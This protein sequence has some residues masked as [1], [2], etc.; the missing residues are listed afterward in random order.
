MAAEAAQ[1]SSAVAHTSPEAQNSQRETLS[2]R[3]QSGLLPKR[4]KALVPAAEHPQPEPLADA[5]ARAYA[6]RVVAPCAA[7]RVALFAS[8]C[9]RWLRSPLRGA[10]GGPGPGL[11]GLRGGP[12]RAAVP[13]GRRALRCAALAWVPPSPAVRGSV[14]GS[15][16]PGLVGLSGGAGGFPLGGLRCPPSLR[17]GGLLLRSPLGSRPPAP[18]FAP[19]G[20]CAALA[21]TAVT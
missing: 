3:G 17:S 21:C 15:S 13:L 16:G 7:L 1:G 2:H 9:R 8:W 10:R 12:R 11:W 14:V 18:P 20:G 6:L 19:V 4:Q 5:R